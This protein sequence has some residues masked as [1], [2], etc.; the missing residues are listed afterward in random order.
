MF[1]LFSPAHN[2]AFNQ[3]DVGLVKWER[4]KENGN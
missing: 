4:R 1:V 2:L 3:C